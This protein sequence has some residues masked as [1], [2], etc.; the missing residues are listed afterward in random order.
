MRD[1]SLINLST[2]FLSVLSI[3]YIRLIGRYDFGS[4]YKT[5]PGLEIKTTLAPLQL[6]GICPAFR[7]NLNNFSRCS[8][9]KS[10][11]FFKRAG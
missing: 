1:V 2:S 7:L 10:L 9:S 5:L 8:V 4:A 6:F 11:P 3:K